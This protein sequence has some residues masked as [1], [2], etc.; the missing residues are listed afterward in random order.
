MTNRKER[1]KEFAGYGYTTLG[2]TVDDETIV[3][4]RFE[5]GVVLVMA[6]HDQY[7]SQVRLNAE[8]FEALKAIRE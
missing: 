8:Q 2:D 6:V 3:A 1:L 5:T 4:K 7:V